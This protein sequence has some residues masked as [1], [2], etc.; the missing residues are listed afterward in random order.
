HRDYANHPSPPIHRP[1]APCPLLETAL[2]PSV[3]YQTR[4]ATKARRIKAVIEDEPL[5]EFGPRRAKEMDAAIWG[6]PAACRGG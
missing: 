1:L 5:M 3:N 4:I 2:L 6:T